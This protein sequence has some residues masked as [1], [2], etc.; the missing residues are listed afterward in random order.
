MFRHCTFLCHQV[1][2]RARKKLNR[3]FV[4]GRH[5]PRTTHPP[6][7]SARV[8]CRRFPCDTVVRVGAAVACCRRGTRRGAAWRHGGCAAAGADHGDVRT[9]PRACA[10]TLSLAA[11]YATLE[12][13]Q[14]PARGSVGLG[15]DRDRPIPALALQIMQRNDG[16]RCTHS[17]WTPWTNH[18]VSTVGGLCPASLTA[19]K[20][21]IRFWNFMT[22]INMFI[23][24]SKH[25]GR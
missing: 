22:L 6:S 5:G 12:P 19:F 9:P 4:S 21:T 16:A 1:L 20:L 3:S 7:L 2:Y 18:I 8:F 10:R 24:P 25:V 14:I 13:I 15:G 11:R 23:Y 17:R